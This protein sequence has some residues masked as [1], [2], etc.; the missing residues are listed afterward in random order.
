MAWI[1]TFLLLIPSIASILEDDIHYD[2]HWL[3]EL[4]TPPV[5]SSISLQRVRLSMRLSQPIDSD[6]QVLFMTKR[7]EKYSCV[8]PTLAAT[9]PVSSTL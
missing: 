9:L 8:L 4:L 7:K 2:I 1:L 5:G 3:P 6:N